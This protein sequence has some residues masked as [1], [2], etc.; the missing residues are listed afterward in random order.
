MHRTRFAILF[1]MLALPALLAAR[2]EAA[3]QLLG[4][5]ASNG[6]PTPLQCQSGVCGGFFSSFCLQQYRPAPLIHTEYR[7]AP[8]G[9]LTLVVTRADSTRLRLPAEGLVTIRSEIDFSSVTISIAEARLKG[10]GAVSA[11]IEVAP[12]T[13]ILP[14]PVAGDATPQ[15]GE[16]IALATG[17]LRQLAQKS[18]ENSGERRDE[19]R[20]ATLLVNS[21]PAEEPKTAAGRAAVW[22]KALT[23]AAGQKLDPAAVA[24]ASKTYKAC[25]V[26]ADMNADLDLKLCLQ[27]R[28]TDLMSRFNRDFW[29]STGGS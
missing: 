29:D 10:L 20:L 16:E 27:L 13:S 3:P 28:Q 26:T 15:S 2:A 9:G 6:M 17:K 4:L 7:L 5:V 18:F 8:P 23:L 24:N 21:L 25:G 11:A 19:A 22:N 1:A 12:L 14:V